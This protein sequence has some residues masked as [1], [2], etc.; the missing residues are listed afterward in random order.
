MRKAKIG[1]LVLVVLGLMEHP[2]FP[3][4]TRTAKS[5]RIDINTANVDELMSIPGID[6]YRAKMID[7]YRYTYGVFTSVNKLREVPDITDEIFQQIKDRV[8]VDTETM[9]ESGRRI[10]KQVGADRQR[11]KSGK[12]GGRRRKQI[13]EPIRGEEGVREYSKRIR[14]NP[15]NAEAYYLRGLAYLSLDRYP[16]ARADF[17]RALRLDPGHAAAYRMRAVVYLFLDQRERAMGDLTKAIGLDPRNF[18]S[19]LNRGN[20]YLSLELTDSALRDLNEAVRLNPKNAMAYSSRAAA[21]AYADCPDSAFSDNDAALGLYPRSRAPSIYFNSAP[22]CY[23]FGRHE[24]AIANLTTV[25]QTAQSAPM[26]YAERC[27]SYLCLQQG[28]SAGADAEAALRFEGWRDIYPLYIAIFGHFGY[29]QAQKNE[30]AQK[31][32]AVG[33]KKSRKRSWP[34]PVI[35]Y[36]RNEISEQQMIAQAKDTD[37]LTEAKTFVG[38]DLSFKGRKD[39]AKSHLRWVKEHGNRTFNEYPLALSELQRLDAG[40]RP[41]K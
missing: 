5:S 35:R 28:D 18:E 41:E 40:I 22:V 20:L 30:S 12:P 9:E 37:Q 25:I 6:E 27:L 39:E 7:A 38:L 4:G 15:K 33:L 24:Q 23:K 16:P 10:Q 3:A 1:L 17:D 11:A 2:G 8:Y 31:I 14:A 26:A 13:D 19:H 34:Y 21:Y 32:L 29:R 36:L